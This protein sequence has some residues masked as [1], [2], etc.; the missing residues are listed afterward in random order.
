MLTKEFTKTNS[1][2]SIGQDGCNEMVALLMMGELL[3]GR[4][5]QKG[6]NCYNTTVTEGRPVPYISSL[7]L[8]M[9]PVSAKVGGEVVNDDGT[10]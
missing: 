3:D 1:N 4:L 7:R 8:K 5:L 10:G 6:C 9:C 2:I